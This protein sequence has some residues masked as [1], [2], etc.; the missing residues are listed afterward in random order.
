MTDDRI[1]RKSLSHEEATNELIINKGSQFDPIIVDA[2]L[3]IIDK[4]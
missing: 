3:E 4:K 2:F 1:Y